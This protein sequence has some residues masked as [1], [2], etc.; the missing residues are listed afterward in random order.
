MPE[1]QVLHETVGDAGFVLSEEERQSLAEA[2][3]DEEESEE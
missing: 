1:P 2:N 3:E